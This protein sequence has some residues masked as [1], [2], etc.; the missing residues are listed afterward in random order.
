L[1]TIGATDFSK[2]REGCPQIGTLNILS[3]FTCF[4]IGCVFG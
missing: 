1:G 3:S 4:P 2:Y